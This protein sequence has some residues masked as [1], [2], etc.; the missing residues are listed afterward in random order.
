VCLPEK[1]RA[2]LPGAETTAVEKKGRTMT[3]Q[4]MVLGMLLTMALS[5]EAARVRVRFEDQEKKPV[6][7]VQAKLVEKDSA[8]EYFGKTS[9]KKGEAEFDKVDAGQYQLLAQSQGHMPNKTD[10]LTVGEKDLSI[11]I[12]LV[13]EDFYRKKESD[14]NSALTQGKFEEAA[15]QYEAL[16]GLVPREGV[17]WS[18]LAKAYVGARQPQKARDAA[19]KAAALDASQYGSLESQVRGWVS[20]EEGRQALERQDFPQAVAS[21]TEALSIDSSNADAYYALALAYGHQ[22]KYPEALKNIDEALKLK[23]NEAGFLEVKR[24]LTH[25]A[26]ISGK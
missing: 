4:I 10:W 11:N 2:S 22:K 19:Q 20:L 5:A 16:L 25:N 9:N 1:G 6:A 7:S 24:I 23:P 18:N 17:L 13:G 14:G 12:T 8:K 3:R 26:G 21:L 15:G